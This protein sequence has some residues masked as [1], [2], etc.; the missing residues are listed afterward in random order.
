VRR[1]RDASRVRG[2]GAAGGVARCV[3]KEVA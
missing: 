2:D 1:G 3:R